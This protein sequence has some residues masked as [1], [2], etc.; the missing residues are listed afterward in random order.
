MKPGSEACIEEVEAEVK[1]NI[2]KTRVVTELF[3]TFI[4]NLN[5]N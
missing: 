2:E 4:I 5:N 3:H 1:C